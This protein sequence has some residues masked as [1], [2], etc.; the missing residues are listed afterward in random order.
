MHRTVAGDRWKAL[1]MSARKL[2]AMP[3]P[4][5]RPPAHPR[6]AWRRKGCKCVRLAPAEARGP[7]AP[8]LGRRTG[9]C[10]RKEVTQAEGL[11]E[12]GG[13][14]GNLNETSRLR[15]IPLISHEGH[16]RREEAICQRSVRPKTMIMQAWAWPDLNRRPLG[17]EPSALTGLSYRP[18]RNAPPT[19]LEPVTFW[20]LLLSN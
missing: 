5:R 10:W 20:L 3:A 18:K 14:A 11:R 16:R 19:G 15:V 7:Q 2:A 6:P 12:E 17:Y 13:G 4:C 8:E 9:P 1:K